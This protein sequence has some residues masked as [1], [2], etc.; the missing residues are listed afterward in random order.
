MDMATTHISMATMATTILPE[1]DHP[2]TVFVTVLQTAVPGL[3]ALALLALCLPQF[4]TEMSLLQATSVM[5]RVGQGES[6]PADKLEQTSI[7]FQ[8]AAQAI[9]LNATYWE[10]AALS[11][12][13]ASLGTGNPDEL[14]R[15]RSDIHQA[16][17]LA[18][19][20]S[21]IWASVAHADFLAGDISDETLNALRLSFL[22]G[23]LELMEISVRLRLGLILWND[24]PTD[25][26]DQ[27]ALE[28]DHLWRGH[29]KQLAE[30]Y[31]SLPTVAKNR[32][33]NLLP[34]GQASIIQFM[35]RKEQM[36]KTG[37]R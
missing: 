18:P 20:K 6:V 9:P 2:S 17:Q 4:R 7:E 21:S 8:T 37:T 10:S 22:T 12:M 26:R 11:G 29:Q 34:N 25:L 19:S 24:L 15:I 5:W 33:A 27:V 32:V 13:L 23:R 1:T 35:R 28:L 16:A 31:V 30:I 3:V 14:P 36:D